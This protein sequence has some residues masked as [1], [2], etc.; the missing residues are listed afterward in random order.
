[1][2]TS[3]SDKDTGLLTAL[4][5]HFSGEMIGAR[6]KLI[7]LFINALCKVKT[8]NYDRLA[9]GFEVNAKKNS[10]Y[11]RIQ[12]FMAEFELPMK[13]ISRLIFRLLPEKT[14]LTLVLDRTNWKFGSKNINL[15]R[16][17]AS[18]KNVA[19][20][21]MFTMLDKRGNSNTRERIELLKN[22][23]LGLVKKLSTSF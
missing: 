17:G 22:I 1:M 19:F 21:L 4:K 12:R 3:L 9:S 6:I 11:R 18:Y 23:L 5:A 8:I 16:L 15:L 7:C 14:D 2:N 13:T 10:F 20:P